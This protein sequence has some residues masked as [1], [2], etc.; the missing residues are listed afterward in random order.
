M[1]LFTV[2]TILVAAASFIQTT[3]FAF[4]GDIKANLVFALLV[5]IANAEKNWSK[6]SLLILISAL[7]LRFSPTIIWIDVIFIFTSFL[8]VA[9]VDY[10]PWRKGINSV[11][12]ATT[13]TIFINLSSFD[14]RLV[15]LEIAVNVIFVI[16]FFILFEY[17]YGKKKQSK[18]KLR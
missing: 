1:L 13:G 8:M 9:L 7:I 18:T 2:S 12:A 15:A 3:N 11:A 6:R 16:A 10:L 5:V 4:M 17:L 14:L